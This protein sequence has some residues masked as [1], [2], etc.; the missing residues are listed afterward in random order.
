M[1]HER[2]LAAFPRRP[3][4]LARS[5]K[6]IVA[7][8]LALLGFLLFAGLAGAAVYHY[9]PALVSDTTMGANG[10]P[11][12]GGWGG[13]NCT[14][15][16]RVVADCTVEVHYPPAVAPAPALAAT[17]DGKG[18][19][20]AGVAGRG[21]ASLY[22]EIPMIFFGTPDRDAP[23]SVLRDR[24]NP[25]RIATSLGMSYLTDRWITFALLAGILAALGIACLWGMVAGRR[26][27]RARH[28]LTASPN[29]TVVTLS[30]V[31]RAKGVATWSYGW[32]TGARQFQRKENLQAPATEPLLLDPERGYALAL[33][34]QRGRAM[35]VDAG[36]T[37]LQLTEAERQTLL[38]AVQRDMPHPP[39]AAQPAMAAR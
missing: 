18:Q 11:V 27:Q 16:R 12:P 14:I 31:Q 10:E 36:A 8:V 9:L 39:P 21:D 38:D 25:D 32:N 23:F 13:W 1:A 26:T 2:V 34:D 19:P 17:A 24:G 15:H 30:K 22:R 29:P 37:N 6:P 20:Q 7:M 3:L 35:L 5:R 28:E 4:A 33:T